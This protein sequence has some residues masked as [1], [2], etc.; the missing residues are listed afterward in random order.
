MTCLVFFQSD[1]Q[2]YRIQQA[3]EIATGEM[4]PYKIFPSEYKRPDPLPLTTRD[5]IKILILCANKRSITKTKY[6]QRCATLT[7]KKVNDFE[8]YFVV[9][10]TLTKA[11]KEE[12]PYEGEN[13]F[14]TTDITSEAMLDETTRNGP[15]DYVCKEDCPESSTISED[16]RQ[17]ILNAAS[18]QSKGGKEAIFVTM[19]D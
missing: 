7:G 9:T 2:K 18:E 14:L 11:Q 12:Q 4:L 13:I 5:I 6:L 17:K 19:N 8:V 10:F 15:F 16:V 1:M 3:Y